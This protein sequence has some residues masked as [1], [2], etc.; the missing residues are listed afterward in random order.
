ME[1]GNVQHFMGVD[2]YIVDSA[3]AENYLQ[4]IFYYSR[5][6]KTIYGKLCVYTCIC[7]WM[8]MPKYPPQ[9]YS[10]DIVVDQCIFAKHISVRGLIV[11]LFL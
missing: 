8:I 1:T 9:G 2:L 6:K 11:D 10:G 7:I 3:L 5:I 4:C